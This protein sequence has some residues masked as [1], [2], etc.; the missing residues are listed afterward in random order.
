MILKNSQFLEILSDK[1]L[2]PSCHQDS[3]FLHF[4][5]LPSL[6]S[7]SLALC[8][9][10]VVNTGHSCVFLLCLS[11]GHLPLPHLCS[12][13]SLDGSNLLETAVS[14]R[15]TWNGIHV[16]VNVSLLSSHPLETLP[17]KAPGTC[18]Q[19]ESPQP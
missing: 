18:Q 12:Q 4:C 1:F 8:P 17:D 19:V 5:S 10:A 14:I 11:P 2:D 9:Q 16:F 13:N 7:T 15:V 6:L 3:S